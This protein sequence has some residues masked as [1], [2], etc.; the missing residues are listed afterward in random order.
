ME[1]NESIFFKA[2]EVMH[3]ILET[4][5]QCDAYQKENP[6]S[7]SGWSDKFCRKEIHRSFQGFGYFDIKQEYYDQE[8]WNSVMKLPNDMREI[9][10]FRHYHVK[11]EPKMLIPLWIVRALPEGVQIV[12]ECIDGRK[13]SVITKNFK[14]YDSRGGCIAYL[15]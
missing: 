6:D 1:N 9:L 14:D 2:T 5:A 3:R 13:I 15:I 11:K 8:F 7:V 4:A 12:G 10:G